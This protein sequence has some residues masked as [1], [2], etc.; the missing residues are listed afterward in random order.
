M[1]PCLD[2][3]I[4]PNIEDHRAEHIALR[5][6]VMCFE[7]RPIVT[8]CTRN[9]SVPAPEGLEHSRQIQAQTIVMKDWKNLLPV[10]CVIS[11]FQV[12]VHMFSGDL[13]CNIKLHL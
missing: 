2:N 6:P 7:G 1:S 5:N 13:G 3:T 10:D 4:N 12:K 11:L 8:T 9:N